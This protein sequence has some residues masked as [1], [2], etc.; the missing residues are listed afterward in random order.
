MTGLTAWWEIV[1]MLLAAVLGSGGMWA[2]IQKKS[3]AK[4]Y[5]KQ[6]LLGLSHDKLLYLLKKYIRR[7]SITTDEFENVHKYLYTP[8]RNLGG[9]GV[10]EKLMREVER[11]P[12]KENGE[13]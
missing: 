3:D 6:M 9:N 10:V 2:L 12:I 8:Y 13:D 11:L 1:I 7:G 4:D 5:N